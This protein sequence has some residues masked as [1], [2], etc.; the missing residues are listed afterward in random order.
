MSSRVLFFFQAEDGI[1]DWSVTGVQTC[2][3]PICVALARNVPGESAWVETLVSRQRYTSDSSSRLGQSTCPPIPV[4]TRL[5]ARASQTLNEHWRVRSLGW[6]FPLKN[7]FA[8]PCLP[9]K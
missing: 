6:K 7:E 4:E 8:K 2:A 9:Q 1:R 3:L 5:R